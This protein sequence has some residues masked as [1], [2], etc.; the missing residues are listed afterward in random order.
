MHMCQLSV[1]DY[2][3]AS[4]IETLALAPDG[5]LLV[6]GWNGLA[7]ILKAAD[8]SLRHSL[9]QADLSFVYASAVSPDG[10]FAA[11]GTSDRGQG[12]LTLWDTGSGQL[13]RKFEGHTDSV[14][15]LAFSGD[16]RRLLS[17]S[18]DQTAKL[19]DVA[20]GA[21]LR[22]LA[23]HRGWVWCAAFCYRVDANKQPLAEEQVVTASQDGFALVW[24]LDRPPGAADEKS[25]PFRGHE[26]PVYAAAFS[27]DGR[28][29]AT[30][31]YD[32]RVLVW[33]PGQ[34]REFEFDESHLQ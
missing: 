21:L 17:G 20:S 3:V 27:P 23:G 12:F 32:K 29:V 14:V 25:P 1:R 9:P 5:S 4:P 33:E 28:R 19:W 8:G 26:G 7:Q 13:V 30:A 6:G 16:G 2:H 11:L 18:F 34:L 24:R 10:R 22:T 31:G 15:S